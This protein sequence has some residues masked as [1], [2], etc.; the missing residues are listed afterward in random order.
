MKDSFISHLTAV[1][2]L[3][4]VVF[5]CAARKMPVSKIQ[6][7]N[8]SDTITTY[9]QSSSIISLFR[10]PPPPPPPPPSLLSAC[11]FTW[12]THNYSDLWDSKHGQS[13]YH[14]ITY[15]IITLSH[16]TLSHYHISH[17]H[18]I[19]YAVICYILTMFP[20]FK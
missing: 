1:S 12:A 6:Q 16:I 7:Y 2:W 18:I 11:V 15:H 3:C 8:G 4:C 17:Y 14:I 5:W 19:T 9:S 13:H 20:P 10:P